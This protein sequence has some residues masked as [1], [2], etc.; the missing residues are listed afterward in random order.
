LPTPVWSKT[1]ARSGDVTIVDH[2]GHGTHVTGTIMG[3]G[4]R[5]S[6][7]EGIAPGADLITIKV[8]GAIFGEDICGSIAWP[9]DDPIEDA[10]SHDS[11]VISISLKLGG[12]NVYDDDSELLDDAV[13]GKYRDSGGIKSYPVIV[14]AAGNDNDKVVPPATAKNV[15]SVGAAKVGNNGSNLNEPAADDFWFSNYGP[16]DTGSGN[17][18]KPDVIAPGFL[19]SP[20]TWYD[21]AGCP[22][23]V[24]GGYYCTRRGTS[25]AAP[26]VSGIATSLLHAYPVFKTLPEAVKAMIIN[27]AVE[28]PTGTVPL[29]KQGHGHVNAFYSHYNDNSMYK[30]VVW[31]TGGIVYGDP[32]DEYEFQVP[33]DFK[34]IKATLVYIDDAGSNTQQDLDLYMYDSNDNEVSYSRSW[35]DTVEN[36][37]V[38]SGPSGTWKVK[39]S[40]WLETDRVTYYSVVVSIRL[41]DPDLS[42]SISKDIDYITAP[43]TLFTITTDLKNNGYVTVGSYVE[44][45]IPNGFRLEGVDVHRDDGT[46]IGLDDSRL[47]NMSNEYRVSVGET[48]YNHDRKVVWVLKNNAGTPNGVYTF[49]VDY[50][51]MNHAE[52]EDSIQVIIGLPDGYSCTQDSECA[53]GSCDNDGV[54]QSDDNWCFTPHN[55]YFDGEEPTYCE[56]STGSGD[57]DCDEREVGDHTNECEGI[58]Y[59]EE[60]CDSACNDVDDTS[61]FECT[62]SGCSCSEALCDSLTTGSNIVTCSSGQTYFADKCTSTAGGEDRGDNICRS[63]TFAGDCTADVECDGTVAGTGWCDASC[64]NTQPPSVISLI[65]TPSD[66]AT[67][68]SGGSYEFNVTVTDGTGVEKVLLEFNGVNYTASAIGDVYNVSLVDLGVGTYNYRWF[69][70]DTNGNANNTET[71]SYTID[72]ATSTVYTYINHSRSNITITDKMNLYLNGSLEVGGGIIKLYNNGILINSGNSP[73]SNLTEFKFDGMYNITTIYEGNENYTNS[74][75]TWWLNVSIILPDDT[76]KFIHKNSLGETVAWFG[77]QGNV[78]IEGNKFVGECSAPGSDSLI[79]KNSTYNLMAFIN[80]TG[81]LCV[82]SFVEEQESCN[83]DADAFRIR[84]LS[85]YNMSY[86]D[87]EGDMCLT[88][89][90]YEGVEL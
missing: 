45:D 40:P 3:D 47:Y 62:D 22:K 23:S 84:N 42:M 7:Y 41:K 34:E 43:E 28:L 68:S 10:I 78:V 69:A 50:G 67:Y 38:T 1:Y 13:N 77:T 58:D 90:L 2:D 30:T 44:L 14:V 5:D 87:V 36:I 76:S 83:P 25:M 33:S 81:D 53:L 49:N 52:K 88:G 75:E 66:P 6:D 79:I 89:K 48:V 9:S 15:I 12:N 39:V 35:A 17:R 55:T 56:Y 54:G 82:K 20:G 32:D 11:D 80:S 8:C 51:A 57:Q 37:T 74:Y 18:V 21:T 73:L 72:K 24:G 70:N 65:E 60:E 16:I 59:Y 46:T 27:S 85:Y 86:I 31:S 63:S 19:T 71:G 64:F 61:D 26:V 4:S 29:S